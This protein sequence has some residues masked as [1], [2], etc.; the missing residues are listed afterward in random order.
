MDR[1]ACSMKIQPQ[2]TVQQ[3]SDREELPWLN[4]EVLR[5]TFQKASPATGVAGSPLSPLVNFAWTTGRAGAGKK[6]NAFRLKGR[7]TVVFCKR[8]DCLCRRTQENL[9]IN[10]YNY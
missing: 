10:Y 7:R 6:G 8:Y 4:T 3:I 2:F 9:W 5:R 1:K